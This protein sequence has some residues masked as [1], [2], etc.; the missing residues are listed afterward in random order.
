MGEKAKVKETVRLYSKVWKLPTFRGILARIAMSVIVASFLMG[1][2]RSATSGS[3]VLNTLASYLVILALPATIGTA[4]LYLIVREKNSPLDIRRTSGVM[5]YAL[6]IWLSLG[7][8]GALI[9][10]ILMSD[11][12][13]MRLMLVGMIAFFIFASFLVTG[14][15]D[16]NV[17]RNFI[18]AAMPGSI[19]LV[20]ALIVQS[21]SLLP[22]F[23]QFWWLYVIICT[24]IAAYSVHH[25]F[26]SVSAPF[27]RDLG[28]N[29]PALLRAFGHEYLCDNPLP[30]EQLMSQI[31]SIQDV[32]LDIIILRNN[33]EL[34]AVAINLLIHP[35]P[36]RNIGSSG[37]PSEI[38]KYVRDHYNIPTFV[39]HGTCT[40]HQNLT[41]KEDFESVFEELDRLIKSTETS[42]SASGPFWM[43]N[44]KFKAWTLF[45]GANAL[46]ITTSAPEYTDDIALDVAIQAAEKVRYEVPKIEGVTIADAHNCINDNAVSVM[47]DDP[48]AQEY[49]DCVVDAV[50]ESSGRPAGQIHAGIHQETETGITIKE[51]I[52][53]GGITAM[54]LR[55]NN[56]TTVWISIDG[57]NM[58]P[59]MREE[60][61]NALIQRGFDAAEVTTTDTHI[62]N[63]I[64]LSSKGYPPVGRYKRDDIITAVCDIALKAREKMIPVQMGIGKGMVKGLRTYGEKG[65]DILTQDIVEAASIAKRTGTRTGLMAFLVSLL[66]AFVL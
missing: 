32:P 66:L 56:R 2:M 31:A 24:P 38:I 4:L 23:P 28:I 45:V 29:G 3:P 60:I 58:E 9:D 48:E 34:V 19:W 59:G 39:F 30:F 64:S 15:S 6:F 18:A 17:I 7:S 54:V 11:I 14:L 47:P 35:G 37:L 42:N 52:G 10:F 51:G 27:D 33:E 53:P 36:F 25:I 5:Q 57:N 49:I 41:S 8:V 21:T 44:S 13:E 16:R 40:H 12:F 62:V 43:P 65:F 22:D 50:R 46:V 55:N 63:A 26:K 1:T 61:Q 20:S